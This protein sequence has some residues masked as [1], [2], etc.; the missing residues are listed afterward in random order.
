M[1]EETSSGRLVI[2]QPA[3][4]LEDNE[5]LLEA[6][7]RETLEET[8]WHVQALSVIGIYL[9]RHPRK[10][11]TI[12]RIAFAA[13]AL[14]HDPDRILDVG[15]ERALWLRKDELIKHESRLRSPL[16]MRALND[17]LD[18]ERHSLSLVADNGLDTLLNR[19]TSV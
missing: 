19:A 3:G 16:V 14:R 4:H 2:N 1:V 18:G 8:A 9:W 13:K 5:T 7:V 17:Y 15:I 12:L 6:M 11:I 10:K